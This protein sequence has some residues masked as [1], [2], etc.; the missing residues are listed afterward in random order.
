MNTES[1]LTPFIIVTYIPLTWNSG[2]LVAHYRSFKFGHYDCLLSGFLFV[3]CMNFHDELG[4]KLS[5][6]SLCLNLISG[7]LLF[8]NITY[9]CL[10]LLWEILLKS[11]SWNHNNLRFLKM[12]KGISF[13]WNHLFK[14]KIPWV[15]S[16]HTH[17][18]ADGGGG[19]SSAATF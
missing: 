17:F 14:H 12:H 10:Y 19:K 3:N 7:Q 13:T 1:H 16:L 11:L 6:V 15:V 8:I 18:Y 4:M 5:C 9:G 2:T